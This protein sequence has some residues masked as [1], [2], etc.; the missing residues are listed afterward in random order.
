MPLVA[1]GKATLR[2]ADYSAKWKIPL[3]E[4]NEH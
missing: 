1:G 3:L 4:I 2:K